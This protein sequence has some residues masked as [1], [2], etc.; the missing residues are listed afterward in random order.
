[1]CKSMLAPSALSMQAVGDRLKLALNSGSSPQV[2][3]ELD[4]KE[5]MAH[6]KEK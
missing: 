4:W 6:L 3:V 5:S 1:M 2:V